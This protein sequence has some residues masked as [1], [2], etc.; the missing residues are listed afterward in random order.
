MQTTIISRQSVKVVIGENELYMS[1][2]IF[3]GETRLSEVPL[4]SGA[5]DRK[6]AG[7]QPLS[8]TLQGKVLPCDRSFYRNLISQ[9]SGQAVPE[10]TID[11]SEYSDLVLVKGTLKFS[12]KA[13]AGE[14]ILQLKG[15]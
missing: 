7:S 9:Y 11:G 8:I 15:L 1:D 10:I 4:L 5:T 14:C 13:F 6:I 2:M 3:Y 12:D